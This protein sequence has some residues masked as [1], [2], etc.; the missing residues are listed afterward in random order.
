MRRLSFLATVLL[1]TSVAYSQLAVL[2]IEPLAPGDGA[3]R[4]EQSG[5]DGRTLYLST[6]EQNGIWEY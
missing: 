4:A 2:R 1:A 5:P 6:P 3:W